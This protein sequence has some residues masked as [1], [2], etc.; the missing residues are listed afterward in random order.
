MSNMPA[1]TGRQM[2]KAL[3]RAGFRVVRICGSHHIMH[4]VSD[5]SRR[6]IVPVHGSEDLKRGTF[7]KILSDVS[8][9]E[10][11]LHDLL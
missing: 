5:R 11:A 8:M 4:H 6:T 9:S 7:K 1:V 10:Q 2:V 3:E